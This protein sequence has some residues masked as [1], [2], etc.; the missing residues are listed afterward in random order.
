MIN[1]DQ[2]SQ[3]NVGG[4]QAGSNEQLQYTDQQM[5]QIMSEP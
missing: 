3:Y 5:Q 2:L 4:F 1:P